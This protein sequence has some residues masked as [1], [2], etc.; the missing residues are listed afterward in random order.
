MDQQSW[1]N[2][3]HTC[4]APMPPARACPLVYGS[5]LAFAHCERQQADRHHACERG[6]RPACAKSRRSLLHHLERQRLIA[7]GNER[8]S[9]DRSGRPRRGARGRRRRRRRCQHQTL[10][11]E[12]ARPADA[13]PMSKYKREAIKLLAAD[14]KAPKTTAQE[15]MGTLIRLLDGTERAEFAESQRAEDFETEAELPPREGVCA[16]ARGRR[17]EQ[18]RALLRLPQHPRRRPLLVQLNTAYR[19]DG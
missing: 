19:L 16:D 3:K 4:A 2:D 9:E 7:Q 13:D 14:P 8:G 6:W 10:A 15:A 5:R 17:G 1:Q 11:A 12:G 18:D